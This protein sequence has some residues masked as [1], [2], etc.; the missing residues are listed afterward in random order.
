[1]SAKAIYEAD[2]K[3]LLVKF[4]QNSDYV[5]NKFAVVE[6]DTNWGELENDNPWLKE[7]VRTFVNFCKLPPLLF[8]N[9][10][11]CIWYK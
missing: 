3:S 11:T 10:N 9:D 2:G 7:E 8:T 5:K 4:L 1:M 6:R